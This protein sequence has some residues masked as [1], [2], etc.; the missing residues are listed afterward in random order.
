MALALQPVQVAWH[1]PDPAAAAIRC[2]RDFGWG[3]FYLLE[4]IPLQRCS[5]RGNVAR[6]DHSSAYGQAGDL[7]I[8]LITQHD[9]SPS[10]LRDMYTAEQSGVHHVACFVADLDATLGSGA[11]GFETVLDAT[12]NGVRFVM[13]DARALL[14]HMLE[15]YEQGGALQRFYDFV[16]R[17]STG[18]DG[19]DPLRRLEAR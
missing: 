17:K 1:V 6:F 19:K 2:A 10:V 13:L 9:D 11:V 8:E 14:G 16:R 4:H 15:L 5:Y 18:W 7:M 12:S 3:P